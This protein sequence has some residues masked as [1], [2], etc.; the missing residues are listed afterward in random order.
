MNRCQVCGQCFKLVRLK[1][2]F[3]EQQDYYSMMFSQLSNYEI[4]QEELAIPLISPWYD[5]PHASLSYTP[6]NHVYI[7]VNVDTADRLQVDPAFRLEFYREAQEKAYAYIRSYK[8]VERQVLEQ[9]PSR[10]L[11]FG[12]D[13]YETWFEIEKSIKYLDRIFTKV[14]KFDSR[15]FTFPEDHERREKRMMERK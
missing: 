8:E 11:P 6:S 14:E 4:S 1:D 3:N 15:A 12:R 10:K 2:E 13:M 7:H 5:R 9:S